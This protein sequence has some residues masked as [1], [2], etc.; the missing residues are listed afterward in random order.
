MSGSE[1]KDELLRELLLSGD[2]LFGSVQNLLHGNVRSLAFFTEKVDGELNKWLKLSD[3][4]KGE[5]ENEKV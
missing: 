5:I 2:K 1:R 3:R 4:V